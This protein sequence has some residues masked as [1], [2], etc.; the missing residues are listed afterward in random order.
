ME[1]WSQVSRQRVKHIVDSYHLDGEEVAHCAGCLEDWGEL[2][3]TPAIELALVEVLLGNWLTIPMPRGK[4]FFDQ[5][6][7]LLLQWQVASVS[8]TLSPEQFQQITGLDPG[9]V[10][11][12]PELPPP[13]PASR[14][15]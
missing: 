11:G 4:A 15:V 2:F 13:S 9:P 14:P 7:A 10:F 1:L 6:Q 12:S 8:T 3:P 5:V